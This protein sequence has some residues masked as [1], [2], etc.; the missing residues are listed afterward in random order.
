MDESWRCL[1]VRTGVSGES[2]AEL[3]HGSAEV[4][5]SGSLLLLLCV[6]LGRIQ[7]V[8]RWRIDQFRRFLACTHNTQ[9]FYIIVGRMDVAIRERER[10]E[11]RNVKKRTGGGR[12]MQ[13]TWKVETLR[14][15]NGLEAWGKVG[16]IG[17]PLSFCVA[18][19]LDSICQLVR[20][21]RLRVFCPSS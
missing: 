19:I 11:G 3:H 21:L 9:N 13:K 4:S 17:P 8:L 15:E 1:S 10:N 12:W 20:A 2:L 18:H 5:S 7:Q 16:S 14:E 6:F